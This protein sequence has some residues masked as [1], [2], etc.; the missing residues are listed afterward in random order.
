[1]ANEILCMPV[2]GAPSDLEKGSIVRRN[3]EDIRTDVCLDEEEE[4]EHNARVSRKTSEHETATKSS[5]KVRRTKSM[6]G[7]MV[8]RTGSMKRSN[9]VSLS[10][11][12][13]IEEDN[14]KVAPVTK[15]AG[16]LDK[17]AKSRV[18][19][20]SSLGSYEMG[21]PMFEF[22]RRQL[23]NSK[24]EG[25]SA[26][27]VDESKVP[28]QK[29]KVMLLGD[30]GVG[31]S[32]LLTRYSAG[33][34][35]LSWIPDVLPEPVDIETENLMLEMWDTSGRKEYDNIRQF[36]FLRSKVFLTCFSIIDRNS[37]DNVIMKWIPMARNWSNTALTI[38]VCMK[39]DL[40]FENSLA[41]LELE[42]VTTPR[43]DNLLKPFE[44]REKAKEMGVLFLEC[45]S[46]NSIDPFL[47]ELTGL[48]EQHFT[49]NS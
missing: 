37:L 47:K 49:K 30:S 17:Y 48:I 35:P 34:W 33:S 1:M 45:T 9:K 39:S 36:T 6:T 41:A 27:G 2:D 31:K 28:K 32:T 20:K 18:R 19:R 5:S 12:T 26:R 38:M 4:C 14:G 24:P 42:N 13:S 40:S 7:R 21:Q 29:Y 8:S 23:L 10:S 11:Q 25:H 16:D 46:V 15:P 44:W 43:D 3:H 22:Q